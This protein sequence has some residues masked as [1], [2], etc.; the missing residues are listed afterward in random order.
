[1]SESFSDLLSMQTSTLWKVNVD[2]S[3]VQQHF[4]D[5]LCIPFP[6]RMLLSI[7]V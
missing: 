6:F 4:Q 5:A 7:A 3:F 2:F 1:M